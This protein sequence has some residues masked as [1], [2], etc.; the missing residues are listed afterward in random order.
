MEANTLPQP[1]HVS[2]GDC[3]EECLCWLS[4]VEPLRS[5]AVRRHC[6][7]PSF[8]PLAQW[9]ENSNL[10]KCGRTRNKSVSELFRAERE[11]D[12]VQ[13]TGSK[14][15]FAGVGSVSRRPAGSV[16]VRGFL[17]HQSCS[18]VSFFLFSVWHLSSCTSG[19]KPRS[20]KM[21]HGVW[22]CFSPVQRSSRRI[23]TLDSIICLCR[24]TNGPRMMSCFQKS[25][26][27]KSHWPL[28]AN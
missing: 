12:R 2:R 13:P 18:V 23:P 11:Q 21:Q 9:K 1:C 26:V 19:L 14:G 27:L 16:L 5:R 3:G 24:F 15:R 20:C 7:A 4:L 28:E 6:R 10:L 22:K 25:P 8:P 17:R